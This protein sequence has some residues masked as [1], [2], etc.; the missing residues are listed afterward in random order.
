MTTVARA[1]SSADGF[2]SHKSVS[3]T[4]RAKST[5]G[6]LVDPVAM[7]R[8]LSEEV[9]LTLAS[10]LASE[11]EAEFH[12]AIDEICADTLTEE[13]L[14]RISGTRE[15]HSLTHL[16]LVV[17]SSR[18][19]LENLGGL[20]P[21]LHTL[22][23]DGSRLCSLRDLG[24]ELRKLHTLSL[25]SA[26]VEE[27]DGLSAL[28]HLRELRLRDNRIAE[29]APLCT[30]ESLQILDLAHNRVA[31]LNSLEVLGTCSLL[32]SVDLQANP[33]A[34]IPRYR[35]LIHFFAP[36]IRVLDG[37]H[38]A[39]PDRVLL[40]DEA[41]DEVEVAIGAATTFLEQLDLDAT[42]TDAT[43][44]A[45]HPLGGDSGGGSATLAAAE[46]EKPVALPWERPLGRPVSRSLQADGRAASGR[47][48][49]TATSRSAEDFDRLM[50]A[51]SDLTLGTA[52]TFAGAPI[53]VMRRRR[54][55]GAEPSVPDSVVATLD[56]CDQVVSER[57]AAAA[58][59]PEDD[60]VASPAPS[61]SSELLAHPSSSLR[62]NH[63]P[64]SGLSAEGEG[65]S[66]RWGSAVPSGRKELFVATG[67]ADLAMPAA[68][69]AASPVMA[70]DGRRAQS[71]HA[72]SRPGGSSRSGFDSLSMSFD[73]GDDSAPSTNQTRSPSA[74]AAAVADGPRPSSGD[75][76]QHHERRPQPRPH[77][78]HTSNP[79]SRPVFL[80]NLFHPGSAKLHADAPPL[81]AAAAVDFSAQQRRRSRHRGRSSGLPG[82]SAPSSSEA[83][84]DGPRLWST[85]RPSSTNSFNSFGSG[86]GDD[87]EPV[88]QTDSSRTLRSGRG[89]GPARPPLAPRPGIRWRATSD[90]ESESDGEVD[91]AVTRKGL[92]AR[93]A[94][95]DK[96][97]PSPSGVAAGTA[98]AATTSWAPK[99]GWGEDADVSKGLSE[100]AGSRLGFNLQVSLAKIG[101]WS[102]GITT[103]DDAEAGGLGGLGIVTR[104]TILAQCS[105]PPT[106]E[107]VEV[108]VS[109][110]VGQEVAA[111]PQ[112]A[113]TRSHREAAEQLP[114]A[115]HKPS[116]RPPALRSATG[117]ALDMS[118]QEL[119]AMLRRPPKHVPQLRTRDGFRRFFA[120]MPQAHMRALLQHAY[121]DREAADAAKRVAKRMDLVADL[122]T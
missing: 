8:D 110:G 19:A 80:D 32:Y 45:Q 40:P 31:D 79:G 38:S 70:R 65:D 55:K 28:P 30:H 115:Q 88:V 27:L 99:A 21:A 94:A 18:Q 76:H 16:E 64:S 1:H 4:Q 17:D 83:G 33:I 102:E 100:R 15:L 58:T 73:V 112:P 57:M 43:V 113:P 44:K 35:E 36:Q 103:E 91:I 97:V 7:S 85:T 53:A 122:L 26:G 67:A 109:T 61:P 12:A 13:K 39:K 5:T 98:A 23:L 42:D 6:D 78:A 69:S 81:A 116:I 46:A 41:S 75:Q 89:K 120:G 3:R 82:P 9:H 90:S 95:A 72:R 84:E 56:R 22:S 108:G 111:E 60:L 119:V 86:G 66:E 14:W 104:S 74:L 50:D 2:V 24:T 87:A 34:S 51:T 101:Q 68:L 114:E 118:D 77:T 37:R 117:P 48:G 105:E 92:K 11:A 49:S 63:R 54:G 47:F 29:L 121:D 107:D 52:L 20:L 10:Q 96:A 106:G 25:N 93:A 59:A 62:S 71:A